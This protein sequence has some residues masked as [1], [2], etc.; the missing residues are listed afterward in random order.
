MSNTAKRIL[1]S[2][3]LLVAGA[4]IAG[5]ESFSG[6]LL[7]RPDWTHTKSGATSVS[8]SFGTLFNWSFTSGT[9]TNQMDQL[10]VSRRTLAA[11]TAETLDLTGG[12]T[13]SF[14]TA[15]TMA[16]VRM[17]IVT[18][19]ATNAS[20]IAVGGAASASFN[21]WAGASND[22]VRVRP[23]GLMLLV[24]PDATGYAIG[25]GNLAV[26]NEG[27]SAVA[28]DIYVGASSQ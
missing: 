23:G 13:N 16:E 15:L 8:E 14:G 3:A 20:T 18:I 11:N 27:A 12:V 25:G 9:T 21:S 24:A 7:V 19:N 17:L 4:V 26:T 22:T 10:W 28:Y 2:A 1:Y 5:A 6:N